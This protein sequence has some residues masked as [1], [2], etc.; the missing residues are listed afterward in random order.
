MLSTSNISS[1]R[2]AK[3]AVATMAVVLLAACGSDSTGPHNANVA[4]TY[5]L[6]TV[7][8]AGLPFTVP[9]TG[10]HTEIVQ[11][12]TITLTSDST[13]TVLV[14]GTVDNAEPGVLGTDAGHYAVSG[15]QVT[16][17]STIIESGH[18]TAIV[19]GTTLTATIP[20][21]FVGS[22]DISFSLVFTKS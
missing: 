18:Y 3:G 11:S 7:N 16:F 9:H 21:V 19:N 15:S 14:T 5:N 8:G 2:S 13:Y 12:A 4:G 1:L 20:G 6:T 22:S 10:D 17:T